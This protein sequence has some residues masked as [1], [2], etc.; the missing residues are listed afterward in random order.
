MLPIST[1]LDAEIELGPRGG[2]LSLVETFFGT[3]T[4]TFY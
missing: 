3:M 4:E 2:S 1:G